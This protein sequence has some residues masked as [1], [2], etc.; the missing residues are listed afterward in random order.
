MAL[1][2]RSESRAAASRRRRK[3]GGGLQCIVPATYDPA[4]PP[5]AGHAPEELVIAATN[6]K[7]ELADWCCEQWWN[8]RLS[9]WAHT[10]VTVVI[11][12]TPGALLHNTLQSMLFI[13]RRVAP[14]WR[15]IG[16]TDGAGLASSSAVDRVLNSAYD[17]IQFLIGQRVLEGKL[18]KARSFPRIANALGEAIAVRQSR[19]QT[20]P[21]IAWFRDG[22]GL[23]ADQITELDQLAR[24]MRV[25]RFDFNELPGSV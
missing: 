23:S 17:E 5:Y 6:A 9:V 24:E 19:N 13:I 12:P 8:D 4:N 7:G 22:D 11:L 18:G 20:R 16:Q 10:S 14:H 3:P 21:L 2:E 15:I 25:D 1:A